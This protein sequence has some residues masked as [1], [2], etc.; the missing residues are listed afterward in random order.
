MMRTLAFGL[1]RRLIEHASSE[2]YPTR[3]VEY[4][5]AWVM[6]AWSARV[7]WPGDMMIG[8]T[9]KYLIIIAPEWF[10]GALG[11]TV[12]AG[13]IYSLIRNGGWALSPKLRFIGAAFGLNWWLALMVLY[14][15]AVETG[16]PDFPM[17]A[18][19]PVF[20]F[21]EIYSCFRCGQDNRAMIDRLAA[22]KVKPAAEAAG[23]G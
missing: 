6:I 21:F 9:Y 7:L 12:G 20:M 3:S 17:R 16:A 13:R 1:A 15:V 10:W 5:L 23:H 14:T 22:E 4:L 2:R 11:V 19:Y 18:A 8:P